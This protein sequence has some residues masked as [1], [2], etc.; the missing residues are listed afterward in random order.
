M[1]CVGGTAGAP[2]TGGG[3]MGRGLAPLP[4]RPPCCRQLLDDNRYGPGNRPHWALSRT[5]FPNLIKALNTELDMDT[6]KQV[7]SLYHGLMT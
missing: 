3:D 5:Q 7:L 4:S 2:E 1:R 6:H